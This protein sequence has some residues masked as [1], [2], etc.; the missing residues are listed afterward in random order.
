MKEQ[1]KVKLGHNKN[2]SLIRNTKTVWQNNKDK[3]LKSKQLRDKQEKQHKNTH[4]F[5]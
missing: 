3:D 4:D 1:I 2:N 5:L